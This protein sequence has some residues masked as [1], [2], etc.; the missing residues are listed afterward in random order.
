L[1]LAFLTRATGQRSRRADA[2]GRGNEVITMATTLI[3]FIENLG[4]WRIKEG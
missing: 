4:F 2:F 3:P 1:P